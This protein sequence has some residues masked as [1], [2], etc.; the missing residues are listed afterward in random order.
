MDFESVVV[1]AEGGGDRAVRGGSVAIIE[2]EL[3][4]ESRKALEW[5]VVVDAGDIQSD[6]GKPVLERSPEYDKT[7]LYWTCWSGGLRNFELRAVGA[8]YRR[9]GLRRAIGLGSTG[10]RM[11]SGGERRDERLS[12]TK[13]IHLG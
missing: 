10:R 1:E 11:L 7:G 13:V 6:G 4:F 2:A 3:S 9:A 5:V 8:S 12:V